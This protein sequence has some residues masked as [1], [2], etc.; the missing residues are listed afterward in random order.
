M[1]DEEDVGT[2]F[3]EERLDFLWREQAAFDP[4]HDPMESEDSRPAGG[5]DDPRQA[6][7]ERRRVALGPAAKLRRVAVWRLEKA[8]VVAGPT[9]LLGQLEPAWSPPGGGEL[10]A[11]HT[12]DR[13]DDLVQR[14]AALAPTR[15]IP[16]PN[17]VAA[18]G[19]QPKTWS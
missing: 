4:L 3:T 18:L 1:C 2:L 19:Q 5:P 10:H 9:E 16:K 15:R 14:S 17:V 12:R 8:N 11:R 13:L 7:Y 6:S